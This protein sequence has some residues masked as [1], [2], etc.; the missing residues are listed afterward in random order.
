VDE[1]A[2]P[3]RVLSQYISIRL[4]PVLSVSLALAARVIVPLTVVPFAGE[5]TL[6][7]GGR[8]GADVVA[9]VC[10]LIFEVPALLDAETV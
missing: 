8:S 10:E 7:D 9:Q 4:T 3:T 6:T 2:V 5:V 1:E